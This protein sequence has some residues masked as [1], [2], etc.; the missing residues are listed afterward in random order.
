MPPSVTSL[1]T[2]AL[3]RTGKASLPTKNKMRST[4][5]IDTRAT[6]LMSPSTPRSTKRPFAMSEGGGV[7]FTASR[8]MVATSCTGAYFP[9]GS[10]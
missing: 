2:T 7:L 10:G 3:V 6:A 1:W 8:G 4:A 5:A 9:L